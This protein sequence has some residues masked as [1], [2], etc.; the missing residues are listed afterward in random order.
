MENYEPFVRQKVDVRHFPMQIVTKWSNPI[1][2]EGFVPFPKRLLRCIHK[3]FNYAEG[4]IDLAIVLALVDFKRPNA[5]RRPS[6][7]YLAFLAGLPIEEFE[8]GLVRLQERGYVNVE[9]DAEGSGH[10]DRCI[11]A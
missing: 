10:N 4:M 2:R 8:R 7:E 6:L 3:I 1:L 5:S 11:L 9:S